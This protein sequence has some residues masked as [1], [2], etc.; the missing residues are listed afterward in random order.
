MI[1]P[2][3]F[4]V[5]FLVARYFVAEGASHAL[6]QRLAQARSSAARAVNKVFVSTLLN[7]SVNVAVLLAAVYGL[8]GRLSTAELMLAVTTV[9]AAS[10]LHAALKLV[11]NGYW[12]YDLSRHMLR[13]GM[14]GPKAW[15]RSHV[16]L[17]V[18]SEFQRM[19]MLRRLVYR[20]SGAPRPHELIE[21]LTREIWKRVAVKLSAIA[22]I[23]ALYIAL[24][25]FHTRP[26]LLHEAVRLNWLQAFLWP[27]AYSIDYFLQSH[28]T[29]WIEHTLRL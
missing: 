27:F 20:L 9:Y 29:A 23:V 28:T 2:L 6:A 10:V 14:H 18:K 8:R 16:A 12:I 25:S 11:T 13:H 15:L 1:E 22:G 19:G 7:V 3:L 21:A 5:L 17:E 4:P 24:F 26:I